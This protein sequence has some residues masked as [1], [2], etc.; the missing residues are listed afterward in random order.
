MDTSNSQVL[1]EIPNP[2]TVFNAGEFAK[3]SL[4]SPVSPLGAASNSH[5]E[6]QQDS[7]LSI[8]DSLLTKAVTSFLELELTYVDSMTI[9]TYFHGWGLGKSDLSQ[10]S[11]FYQSSLNQESRLDR[12]ERQ[13]PYMQTQ[14]WICPHCHD[15]AHHQSDDNGCEW[16]YKQDAIDAKRYRF[17]RKVL[18]NEDGLVKENA[19]AVLKIPANCT[20]RTNPFV[21]TLI[22]EEQN[23]DQAID[24]A[25]VVA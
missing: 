16:Q 17:L 21:W 4:V 24:K 25:M 7:T 20:L 8:D 3:P 2:S 19:L 11:D 9:N 10:Y 1:G 18:L 13:S 22:L 12:F 6:F 5:S 14:C 15:D 23:L